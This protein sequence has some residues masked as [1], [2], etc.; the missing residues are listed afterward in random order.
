MIYQDQ[1]KNGNLSSSIISKGVESSIELFL[2][3]GN[4]RNRGSHCL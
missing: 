3:N 1:I 2:I 4:P